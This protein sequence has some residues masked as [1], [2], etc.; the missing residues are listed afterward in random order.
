MCAKPNAMNTPRIEHRLA[1]TRGTHVHTN[2]TSSWHVA[3]NKH[4]LWR[5]GQIEI[6]FRCVDDAHA[7][8][9]TII[10]IIARRVI[11]YC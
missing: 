1:S 8:I 7:V 6:L 5:G 3:K 2:I 4:V 11:V 9:A 10:V